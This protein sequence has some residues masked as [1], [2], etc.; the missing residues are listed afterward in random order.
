MYVGVG[1]NDEPFFS[2]DFS[3]GDKTLLLKLIAFCSGFVA[4]TPSVILLSF[5]RYIILRSLLCFL[6]FNFLNLL[7]LR[8]WLKTVMFS[9]WYFLSCLFK[10]EDDSNSVSILVSSQTLVSSLNKIASFKV[11]YLLPLSNES[12]CNFSVTLLMILSLSW[13]DALRKIF[14]H[15]FCTFDDSVRKEKLNFNAKPLGY[16]WFAL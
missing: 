4:L 7:F 15:I 5:S 13:N 11:L 3:A 9:Y 6:R 16:F 1:I 12:S 8:W 10:I 2:R 14:L